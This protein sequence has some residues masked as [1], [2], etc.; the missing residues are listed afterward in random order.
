MKFARTVYY[1]FLSLLP[2]YFLFDEVGRDA[3][4]SYAPE[5]SS[6]AFGRHVPMAIR[7]SC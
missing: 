7:Y 6:T 5:R 4:S 1:G 2:L 3:P